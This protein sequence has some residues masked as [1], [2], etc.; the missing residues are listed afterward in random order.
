MLLDETRSSL[1]FNIGGFGTTKNINKYLEIFYMI[2][3]CTTN[4]L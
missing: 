3:M 4:F 2:I 1:E